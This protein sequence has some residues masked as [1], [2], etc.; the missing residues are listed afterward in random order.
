MLHL[1]ALFDARIDLR[2]G[3]RAQALFLRSHRNGRLRIWQKDAETAAAAMQVAVVDVVAQAIAGPEDALALQEARAVRATIAAVRPQVV[4][5]SP[6]APVVPVECR[7]RMDA[8]TASRQVQTV[9][10]MLVAAVTTAVVVVGALTAK[11]PIAETLQLPNVVMAASARA[12]PPS[13]P[14]NSRFMTD[15]QF[16][17]MWRQRT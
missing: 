3:I 9:R 1:Q 16:L 4:A 11:T 2:V 8:A 17:T 12:M 14:P 13:G 5:A 6:P 15:R 10:E 7:R